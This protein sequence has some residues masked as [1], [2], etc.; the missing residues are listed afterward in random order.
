MGDRA[1]DA[2][3]DVMAHS[4]AENGRFFGYAKGRENP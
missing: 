1:F 4:R 3:R 2:L